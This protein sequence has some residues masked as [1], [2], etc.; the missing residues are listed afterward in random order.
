[1]RIVD[2]AQQE[3]NNSVFSAG[4]GWFIVNNT[5][6]HRLSDENKRNNEQ[7]CIQHTQ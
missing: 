4:F 3:I 6:S 7:P 5:R 2:D 1:M